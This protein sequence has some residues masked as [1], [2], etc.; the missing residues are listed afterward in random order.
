MTAIILVGG[1][2]RRMGANKAFLTLK[3]KTFL[4]RQIDILTGIFDNVII[5]ANLPQEYEIFNIPVIVDIYPEKGPLG[6]IYTGLINSKSFYTFI[7]ACDMPF[8]EKD[9]ITHLVN[10]TKSEEYDVVIPRNG[11]QLEPLHAIYSTNCIAPI[12]NQI[13]NDNL[14]IVDFFS[15]VKV[16]EVDISNFISSNKHKKSLINLNTLED[17]KR[18]TLI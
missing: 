15:Q 1:K 17:Y 9:L 3:G 8:V 18:E 2:S 6:G 4:E 16:K 11:K 7:L 5:S 12:K 10:Y 13:E 14:R